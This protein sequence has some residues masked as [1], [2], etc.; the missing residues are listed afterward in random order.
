MAWV[1][2]SLAFFALMSEILTKTAAFAM[3]GYTLKGLEKEFSKHHLTKLKA[4]V[5]LI[6]LR[7]GIQDYREASE[8]EKQTV[9]E[10][11]KS[12]RG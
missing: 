10:R 1:L 7:Q 6:R 8:E 5:Y 9:M 12:S 4:E 3:P 2:V 11:W